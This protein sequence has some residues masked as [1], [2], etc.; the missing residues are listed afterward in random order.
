MVPLASEGCSTVV[1]GFAY[2]WLSVILTPRAEEEIPGAK[3]RLS[4]SS[5]RV[6]FMLVYQ[7][8]HIPTDSS[9]NRRFAI[10]NH[11]HH[12]SKHKGDVVFFSS[13]IK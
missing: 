10:V 9:E 11:T 7:Q 8:M 5:T 6:A 12:D 13:F 4:S 1:W 3:H 2:L